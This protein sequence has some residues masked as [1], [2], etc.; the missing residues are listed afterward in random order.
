MHFNVAFVAAALLVSASPAMSITLVFYSGAD[1]SGGVI[2]TS[3]GS[4]PGECVGISGGGSA[5]SIRYS[6]VPNKI[7]FY[8]SGGGHDLCTNGADLVLSGG[9]G[10]GT[11]PAG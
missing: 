2:T 6:G 10:C 8:L 1:C 5:K 4:A 9:S 11:A 3:T 7:E